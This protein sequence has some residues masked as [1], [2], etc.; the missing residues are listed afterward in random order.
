VNHTGHDAVAIIRAL[1]ALQQPALNR[2]HERGFARSPGAEDSDGK[3]GGAGPDDVGERVSICL[4]SEP[5]SLRRVIEQDFEVG[6][7]GH[8]PPGVRALWLIL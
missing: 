6:V 3:L 4:E 7:Q 2:V 1:F 8:R 5:R